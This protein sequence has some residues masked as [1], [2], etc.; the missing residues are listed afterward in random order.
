MLGTVDMSLFPIFLWDQ[1]EVNYGNAGLLNGAGAMGGAIVL[2]NNLQEDWKEKMEGM[3]AYEFA[4]FDTYSAFAGLNWG[5]K[6]FYQKNKLFLKTAQND[7]LYH[8]NNDVFK[9]KNQD[10]NQIHFV[11]ENTLKFKDR[12][13]LHIH[14]WYG[15]TNRKLHPLVL[16][17]DNN[18][19][20]FDKTFKQVLAWEKRG[21]LYWKLQSAYAYD[22]LQYIN[23]YQKINAPSKSHQFFQ[24]AQV[25]YRISPILKTSHQ[26]EHC[27]GMAKSENYNSDA[28]QVKWSYRNLTIWKPSEDLQIDFLLRQDIINKM[29]SPFLPAVFINWRIGQNKNWAINYNIGR[30]YRYPT[31]NDLYWQPG[32]NPDL[33]TERSWTNE[34]G[35][36]YTKER[37]KSK[38]KLEGKAGIFHTA[39]RDQIV[40]RPDTSIANVWR[41]QNIENT[42][43]MGLESEGRIYKKWM[44]KSLMCSMN[45][46]FVRSWE[47][48]NRNRQLIYVPKHKLTL[49]QE[50][51]YRTFSLFL[52]H[53]FTSKRFTSK[54]NEALYGLTGFYVLDVQLTKNFVLKRDH[55]FRI[56]FNI[57]NST[58]TSYSLVEWRPMPLRN[59]SVSLTYFMK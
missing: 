25:D 23:H 58:N 21:R 15:H 8:L 27:Y 17:K 14:I 52:S 51:N 36:S 33:K 12:S 55:L 29:S 2:H 44:N 46:A 35:L 39:I 38:L 3:M 22:V 32:G 48:G 18:E 6:A 47:K 4:S 37:N 59:F 26:L 42:T 50:F 11:N 28:S 41:P 19:A 5:K 7:F 31:L 56:R 13:F 1:I 43:S 53:Y 57:Q 34:A 49:M 24:K 40:W 10:F 16:A 45:Y 20:Q 54:E 30:N 9:R